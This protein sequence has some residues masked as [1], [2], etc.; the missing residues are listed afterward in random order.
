MN[1]QET[2]NA[3]TAE[4][5]KELKNTVY[6]VE[7]KVDKGFEH[8]IARMDVANGKLMK[9]ELSIAG[10]EGKFKYGNIVW[11]FLTVAVGMITFLIGKA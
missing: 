2:I 10:L 9:H 8:V 5:M 3:L 4:G 6:R 1:S 7:E 11:F